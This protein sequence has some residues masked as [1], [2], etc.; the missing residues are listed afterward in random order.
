MV[1]NSDRIPIKLFVDE[2]IALSRISDL[3]FSDFKIRSG[4]PILVQGSAETIIRDVRFSN[5]QID[6]FGEDSIVCRHCEGIDL[7][8]VT[9]SNRAE[10]D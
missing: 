2:G 8:G 4:E 7:S 3:S 9:L 5:V 1:V 10:P 6:T